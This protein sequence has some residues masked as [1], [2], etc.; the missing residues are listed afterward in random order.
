[1]LTTDPVT[2]YKYIFN[3]KLNLNNSILP[4]H[5]YLIILVKNTTATFQELITLG[6]FVS[7]C[8]VNTI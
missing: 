5:R 7:L 3:M 2:F 1:M 6:N 8:I 4:V